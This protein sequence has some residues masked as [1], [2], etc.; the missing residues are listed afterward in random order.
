MNAQ[1][2]RLLDDLFTNAERDVRL[3]RAVGDRAGKAKAQARLETLRAA[4]E[5]YAACHVHAHGE[6]PWP[7]EVAP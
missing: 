1:Y 6:R 2:R 3:A 7:R 5:I 4:L